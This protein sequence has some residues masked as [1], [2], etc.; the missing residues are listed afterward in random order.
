V[1]FF[2]WFNIGLAALIFSLA[3]PYVA[4]H[5]RRKQLAR[6]GIIAT[7]IF[8]VGAGLILISTS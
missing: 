4:K 7:L 2:Q 6:Y 5:P 3:M 8:A 1:T